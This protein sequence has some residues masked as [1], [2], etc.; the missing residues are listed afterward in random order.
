MVKAKEIANF[1]TH[2]FDKFNNAWMD[3]FK[4]K[5]RWYMGLLKETLDNVQK[6]IWKIILKLI[7]LRPLDFMTDFMLGLTGKAKPPR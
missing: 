7:W 6:M 4:S 3:R 2:K 5:L 1:Q